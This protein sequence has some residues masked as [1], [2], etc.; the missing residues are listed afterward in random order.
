M[1][2]FIPVSKPSFSGN[3]KKYL[4]D[5]IESG[6]ISS[7]G[8]YIQKFEEINSDYYGTRHAVSVSNGTV[9]LHIALLTLGIGPGDEVI[10]PSLTF[11]A[12]INAVIHC[13]AV[14]LLADVDPDS[15]TI[16]I[17]RCQQLLSPN[18]KA[19]MPVHIYGQPC[20]MDLVLDFAK[21]N[22]LLI[23]EDCAEAHGARFK[24][25]RIGS[26][27]DISCFSFYGNKIITTGEGGICLTDNSGY[28]EKMRV[29]RDHGMNKEKKFWSDY[30]GYNYR[31]TNMQAA[32]GTAQM[33]KI[34]SILERRMEIDSYYRSRLENVPF[35]RLQ[36][37]FTDRKR[38]PWL[39]SI[40][41][42][43]GKIGMTNEKIS[44]LLLEHNID[45]RIFFRDFTQMI[46]YKKLKHNDLKNSASISAAG[47]NLPTFLDINKDQIDYICETLLK[48]CG[49]KYD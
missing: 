43:T 40:L 18:T 34:D 39:F 1:K 20:N 17:E 48:I 5:C 13:G 27:G 4:T 10:V 31:M 6:W 38:V 25:K 49:R 47:L 41:L 3:E 29:L 24:G 45:S 15:W 2:D 28:A 36:N 32:V 19:I 21:K 11:A 23:I 33:E 7:A 37:D 12:S 8:N 42:D 26:F 35:I 9:A 30:V 44:G 22:N 14:P 46:P 16:D